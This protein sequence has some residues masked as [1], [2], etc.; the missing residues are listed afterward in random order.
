MNEQMYLAKTSM[1]EQK[2]IEFCKYPG[3]T[4]THDEVEQLMEWAFNAS[5][6]TSK[7]YG[8]DDVGF[9]KVT[10]CKYKNFQAFCETVMNRIYSNQ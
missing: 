4:F 8:R 10:V 9:Q 7:V 5:R 2:K 3:E 6:S 1:R